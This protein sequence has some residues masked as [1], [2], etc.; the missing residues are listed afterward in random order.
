[1]L[2]LPAN[3]E[4]MTRPTQLLNLHAPYKDTVI[5]FDSAA[6]FQIVYDSLVF[7]HNVAN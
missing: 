2:S 4:Y 3:L 7:G 6:V 1:M 5:H